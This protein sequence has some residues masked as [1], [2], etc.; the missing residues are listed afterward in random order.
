VNPLC[1]IVLAPGFAALWSW[2][3]RRGADPRTEW[4]FVLGLIA[5]SCA[6]AVM[7]LGA[8]RTGPAGLASPAWLLGAYLLLSIGEL[9]IW[10]ISLAAVTR[11]SPQRHASTVLGLWY[12]AIAI[13]GWLAGE[14]GSLVADTSV[15]R[16]FALL[17]VI[18]VAAACALTVLV[19]L[20]SRLMRSARPYGDPA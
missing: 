1:I 4:K 20:T 6:F 5:M 17:A 15:E 9:C 13:G 18:F 14:V 10:T 3:A 7:S 2:L 11:L 16:V 8:A 12:R 19:P